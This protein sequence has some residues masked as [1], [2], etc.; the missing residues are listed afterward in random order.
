MILPLPACKPNLRQI[1]IGFFRFFSEFTK[2]GFLET[3]SSCQAYKITSSRLHDPNTAVDF[4][5]VV[6]SKKSDF[7]H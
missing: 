6:Q 3:V 2:F 1:Y 7:M 5:T 4:C